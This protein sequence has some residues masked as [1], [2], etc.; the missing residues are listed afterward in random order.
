MITIALQH[1]SGSLL[2]CG[3]LQKFS[4]GTQQYFASLFRFP[5]SSFNIEQEISLGPYTI[6]RTFYSG[7]S[8]S[9][10]NYYV[11]KELS[12]PS[13]PFPGSLKSVL[14]KINYSGNIAW[15]L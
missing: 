12:D 2:V 4:G 10:G 8:R 7:I 1:A 6:P 9:S 11:L 14:M 15:V 3:M 13:K 5:I